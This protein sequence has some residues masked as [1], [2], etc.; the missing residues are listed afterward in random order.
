MKE[1]YKC[2]IWHK[3]LTQRVFELFYQCLSAKTLS[4]FST[5]LTR[6]KI[7]KC[8]LYHGHCAAKVLM[9]LMCHSTKWMSHPFFL[10]F[11]CF[12]KQPAFPQP[13]LEG[14]IIPQFPQA[15]WEQKFPQSLWEWYTLTNHA[16]IQSHNLMSHKGLVVAFIIV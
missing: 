3:D 14:M 12:V 11:D 7:S 13:L 16:V 9:K 2:G 10:V 1:Y 5:S 8:L 6:G 15:L 4:T